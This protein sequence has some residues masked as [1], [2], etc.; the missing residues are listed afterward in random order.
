VLDGFTRLAAAE[1]EAARALRLGGATDALR[2]T[3]GVTIGP[4]EQA[5][6]RRR[7][8]PAWR[9]LGESEGTAAWEEGRAMTVEEALDLAFTEPGKSLR[10]LPKPS[11]AFA[12]L[13]PSRSWRKVSRTPVWPRDST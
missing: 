1:G 6:F 11:S 5:E 8:E 7:L 2:R 13:K 10:V 4:T 12:S 9:A 3:Y